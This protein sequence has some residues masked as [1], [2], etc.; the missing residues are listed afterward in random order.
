MVEQATH[1]AVLAENQR[2][3]HEVRDLADRLDQLTRLLLGQSSERLAGHDLTAGADGPTQ[4]G[5][6][7]SVEAAEPTEVSVPEHKRTSRR[8]L[9][10]GRTAIPDHLPRRIE[11]LLPDGLEGQTLEDGS[12]HV[13]GHRIIGTEVSERIEFVP[14]SLT[15]IETRR[16]K[17]VKCEDPGQPPLPRAATA[18][19]VSVAALAP[20]LLD[21][22][23][24]DES[25][26]IELITRKFCEHVPLYRQAQAFARDYAWTVSRSTLGSWVDRVAVALRPLHAELRRQLLSG[27]YLQMDETGLLV[28]AHPGPNAE[29]GTSKQPK[30]TSHKLGKGPPGKPKRRHQGYMWLARDPVSGLVLFEYHKGRSHALP[31][32]LLADYRGYLQVD[33]WGAYRT[34]CVQTYRRTRS[35]PGR[36]VR[37]CSHP[38]GVLPRPPTPQVLRSARLTPHRSQRG[39]APDPGDVRRRG[40]DRE[41]DR[42]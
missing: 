38:P 14:G 41:P 18:T 26:V 13:P 5:L 32:E 4:G 19:A 39:T 10:P 3:H 17:L 37:R 12:Y 27:D 25:L 8:T 23:I 7:G 15:V 20:R 34:A 22:C 31:K 33:G 21:K 35:R 30:P 16:P 24:A 9:H 28:L 2:L 1:D 11:V 36:P 6:F 29:G 42:R 40:T